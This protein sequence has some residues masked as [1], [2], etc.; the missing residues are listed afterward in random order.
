M[1]TLLLRLIAAYVGTWV[2]VI[3]SALAWLPA[4]SRLGR[5]FRP[6]AATAGL[7]LLVLGAVARGRLGWR[8]GDFLGS[9]AAV[10]VTLLLLIS[11]FSGST[12]RHLLDA[13]NLR[14]WAFLSLFFGLPWLGGYVVGCA[15]LKMKRGHEATMPVSRSPVTPGP[16]PASQ[17][18]SR[19]TLR[20]EERE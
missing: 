6:M 19:H 15:W 13:F 7:L 1:K 4:S 20:R 18:R 2:C 11:H 17:A 3:A 9:V 16:T 12:G 8:L 10:E 5:D 14:W